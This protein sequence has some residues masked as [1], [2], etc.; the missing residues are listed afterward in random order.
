MSNQTLNT[1]APE[2]P[3]TFGRVIGPGH[4]DMA[5]ELLAQAR[6]IAVALCRGLEADEPAAEMANA[7]WAIEGMLARAD[8]HVQAVRPAGSD[9]P[10]ADAPAASEDGVTKVD[11][12]A[13]LEHCG[14]Y[15]LPVHTYAIAGQDL[16]RVQG[17][18]RTAVRVLADAEMLDLESTLRAALETLEGSSKEA[19]ELARDR[20]AGAL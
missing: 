15:T 7:A 14:P 3:E 17:L 11:Q 18:L 5:C 9:R 13:G 6:A 19:F 12:Q 8:A 20:A 4:Q 1:A 16:F 10:P 2:L